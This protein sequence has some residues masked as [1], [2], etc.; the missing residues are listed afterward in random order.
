MKKFKTLLKGLA[1][2]L[3]VPTILLHLGTQANYTINN[4]NNSNNPSQVRREFE[5]EYDLSLRGF[6]DDVE[7]NEGLVSQLSYIF[8]REQQENYFDLSNIT[9]RSNNYLKKDVINQ[10]EFCFL[11]RNE[12]VFIPF[13]KGKIEVNKSS[14]NDTLIHEIKHNKASEYCDNDFYKKW[15][16]L[17]KDENGDSLYIGK[18][19]SEL[20]RLKFVGHYLEDI[21][22]REEFQRQGFI[23]DYARSNI[24]EDIAET[25]SEAEINPNLFVDFFY[26]SKDLNGNQIKPNQ[27]IIGKIRL[28]QEAGLIPKEF[29]EYISLKKAESEVKTILFEHGSNRTKT[30]SPEEY[31]KKSEEFLN[32]YPKT[33]YECDIRFPRAW[34]LKSKALTDAIEESVINEK[35]GINGT[36]DGL[37]NKKLEPV[38][39][40]YKLVLDS[41]F[42]DYSNY[43]SALSAIIDIYEKD[44]EDPINAKIFND[45]LKLF[46]KRYREGDPKLPTRGVN[47]FLESNGIIFGSKTSDFGGLK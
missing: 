43:R 1:K 6:R 17:A 28:A 15:N 44:F 46:D 9:I 40:E 20:S 29:E 12:G 26:G 39:A 41:S 2:L 45:S 37:V 7:D 36:Y 16:E 47:D 25:C 34:C 30:I 5:E 14:G 22:G 32:K 31:L 18:I 10:F 38:L 4:I 27:K 13:G 35:N 33:L 19:K 3:I 8:E 21:I 42:K 11:K 24:G 23:S